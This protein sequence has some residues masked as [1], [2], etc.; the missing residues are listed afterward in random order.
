MERFATV[1]SLRAY[2]IRTRELERLR[3]QERADRILRAVSF[4]LVIGGI[5]AMWV[6]VGWQ[7]NLLEQV[8]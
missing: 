1:P 2:R 7:L 8:H 3:R 4:V 5:L 6:Y